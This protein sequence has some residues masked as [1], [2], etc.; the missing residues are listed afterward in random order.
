MTDMDWRSRRYWRRSA[1]DWTAEEATAQEG[2]ERASGPER[3][4][5]EGKISELEEGR[6]ELLRHV[7]DRDEWLSAHPEAERRVDHLEREIDR[8]TRDRVTAWTT[9]S[10]GSFSPGPLHE[11]PILGLGWISVRNAVRPD[12]D[13]DPPSAPVLFGRLGGHRHLVHWRDAARRPV[14]HGRQPIGREVAPLPSFC[15]ILLLYCVKGDARLAPRRAPCRCGPGVPFVA[16]VSGR[17]GSGD[18]GAPR[19]RRLPG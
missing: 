16:L 19:V 8:M 10:S 14:H 13:D 7:Q 1:R 6:H 18:R 12:E 15:V 2:F 9:A 17:P 4:R 11:S 3:E 5:L